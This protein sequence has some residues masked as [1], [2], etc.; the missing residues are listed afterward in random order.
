MVD[1]CDEV[2]GGLHGTIQVTSQPGK[3]STFQVLLP[4]GEAPAKSDADSRPS[5]PRTRAVKEK[6]R[7]L[8][9]GK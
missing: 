8:H 2:L 4:C 3:G 9:R 5:N 7:R 1:R 6:R